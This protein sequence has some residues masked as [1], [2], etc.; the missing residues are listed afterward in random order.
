MRISSGALIYARLYGDK[1]LDR[2][3][4]DGRM[5]VSV[6]QFQTY[7]LHFSDDMKKGVGRVIMLG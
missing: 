7:A 5:Y 2:R 3:Y 4:G 6:K 1:D